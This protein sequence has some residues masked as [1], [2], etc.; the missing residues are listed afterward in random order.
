M[1]IN[2]RNTLY[3]FEA[4][5][6]KSLIDNL[7]STDIKKSTHES[8]IAFDENF[9]EH[10]Y[11][12]IEQFP[13]LIENI[14]L[15]LDVLNLF[16]NIDTDSLNNT[17]NMHEFNKAK[18][19]VEV[20]LNINLDKIQWHHLKYSVSEYSEGSCW[21]CNDEDH[22]IF[23]YYNEDGTLSTDLLVHEIGHAADFKISRTKNDDTLLLGHITLREAIAFYCQ[24]KYLSDFGTPTM[25]VGSFGSFLFTYLNILVLNYCLK[26]EIQLQDLVPEDII[27]DSSMNELVS[28]YNI[29][30]PSG[31]YGRNFIIEKIY[32]IKSRFASLGDV[33]YGEIQPRF[34]AILGIYLLDKNSDF[35]KDIILSNSLCRDIS[36]IIEI[37]IPNYNEE[38]SNLPERL[39]KY[40]K[41]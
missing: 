26:N 33:V 1:D 16:S 30:D 32:S 29:S 36:S 39:L 6:V 8:L 10:L 21:P 14:Y 38:I 20:L 7:D 13:S 40:F 3:K 18:R 28:S 2:K 9:I 19:Y 25:R 41:L 34:G 22:Y 37:I 15:P 12:S 11:S 27:N 17:I 24:Y 4:L 35:I 23:T 31:E 5:L